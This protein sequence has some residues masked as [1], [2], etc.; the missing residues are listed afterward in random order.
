MRIMTYNIELGRRLPAVLDVLRSHPADVVCVQE[1]N[2]R[3]PLRPAG[4]QAAWLAEQIGA[5]WAGSAGCTFPGGIA[6]IGL[7]LRGEVVSFGPLCD[8]KGRL[9]AF[10][11]EVKTAT[12]HCAV[13]SAH[14]CGVGRPLPLG[15]WTSMPARV[16]QVR[17]ILEWTTRQSLPVVVAGDFNTLGWTVEY[18]SMAR[19]FR[20][21]T[22]A[23]GV[24][25]HPTRPTWGVPMQ[26]DRIFVSREWA[27]RDCEMIDSDASDH[28]PLI[29]TLDLPPEPV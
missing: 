5:R 12:A 19:R 17:R 28:R 22:R 24:R 9:F 2:L 25:R 21:C 11:A 27:V 3:S 18:C 8:R 23:A 6:G 29:A 13:C 7:L 1:A 20:D 10:A 26:L 16:R 15:F 14:L 4:D